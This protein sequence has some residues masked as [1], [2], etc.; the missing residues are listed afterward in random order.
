MNEKY[1]H[2]RP[3]NLKG[4]VPLFS[5][6][7]G[8]K[9]KSQVFPILGRFSWIYLA[10]HRQEPQTSYKSASFFRLSKPFTKHNNTSPGYSHDLVIH[11][12]KSIFN[13]SYIWNIYP[14]LDKSQEATVEARILRKMEEFRLQNFF[15]Q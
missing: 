2:V 15:S 7:L 5:I 9:R 3:K 6:H 1:I 14:C 8:Q 4:S 11:S 10:F 13:S 12:D